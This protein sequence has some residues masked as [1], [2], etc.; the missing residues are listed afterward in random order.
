MR[1]RTLVRRRYTRQL[2]AAKEVAEVLL[3]NK[4]DVDT[5]DVQGMTGLRLRTGRQRTKSYWRTRPI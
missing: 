4:A 5:K 3:A 2:G 1:R